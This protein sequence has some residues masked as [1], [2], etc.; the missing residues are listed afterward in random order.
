MF[1]FLIKWGFTL[2]P[3]V[4]QTILQFQSAVGVN[5]PTVVGNIAQWLLALAV[6]KAAHAAHTPDDQVS[7]P[8]T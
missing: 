6:S 8:P 1:P 5:H 3:L 7:N 2:L 4:A